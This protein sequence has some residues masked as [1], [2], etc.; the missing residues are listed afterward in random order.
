MLKTLVLFKGASDMKVKVEAEI[1]YYPD[2]VVA[3]QEITNN[4][5]E[6]NPCVIVEVISKAAAC[7]D[8]LEKR[9]AYIKLEGLQLYLLVD[10]CKRW[11]RGYKRAGSQW[12][13]IS[14]AKIRL[15][16]FPV[17]EQALAKKKFMMEQI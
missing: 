16:T 8:L 9:L 5:Y 4:Y 12:Q 6:A 13:E 7:N 10:S 17:W 14:V 2:V 3:C 11:V 1:F 15:L